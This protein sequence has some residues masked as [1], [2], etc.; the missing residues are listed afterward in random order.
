M[1]TPSA[2]ATGL[3]NRRSRFLP[4]SGSTASPSVSASFP[5]SAPVALP[6]PRSRRGGAGGPQRPGACPG[7]GAWAA[8][9][10]STSPAAL[11]AP[12]PTLGIPPLS[13]AAVI[14]VTSHADQSPQGSQTPSAQRAA[15]G[16]TADPAHNRLTSAGSGAARPADVPA[17]FE[18]SAPSHT[19]ATGTAGRLRPTAAV[20]VSRFAGASGTTATPPS[21]ARI[22]TPSNRPLNADIRTTHEVKSAVNAPNP[23]SASRTSDHSSSRAAH[24]TPS[25]VTQAP[26]NQREEGSPSKCLPLSSQRPPHVQVGSCLSTNER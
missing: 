17:L 1:R 11:R 14:G 23:A 24:H 26:I 4:A 2:S 10:R 6:G 21:L 20:S 5:R 13:R 16:L 22:A 3:G 12:A 18:V 25:H 7:F 8:R 9:G 19:G 15:S